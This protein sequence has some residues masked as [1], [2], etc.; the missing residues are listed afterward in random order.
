MQMTRNAV[1][2][3]SSRRVRVLL[4][5]D[6]TLLVELM[7]EALTEHGFEVEVATDAAAALAHLA[8]DRDVD[9]L[10]TDVNL[11]DGM[12]GAELARQARALRP[13]LPVVYASGRHTAATI[14]PVVSR[15]L[16]LNK[17]YRPEEACRLIGRL[18]IH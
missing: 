8:A 11:G 10:F 5:E 1:A 9:V 7:T 14:A 17:P 4:V 3:D 12:D 13:E 15:S 2:G 18:A 16:F 6:E